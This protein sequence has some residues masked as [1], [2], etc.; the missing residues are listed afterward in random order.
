MRI[1]IHSPLPLPL[2]GI[3]PPKLGAFS[4]SCPTLDT[5]FTPPLRLRTK[6]LWRCVRVVTAR[7]GM[8]AHQG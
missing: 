4:R 3:S 6:L 8:C 2:V 1:C 5:A 7:D